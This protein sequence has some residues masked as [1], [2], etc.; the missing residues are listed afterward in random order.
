LRD[1]A[2][3]RFLAFLDQSYASVEYRNMWFDMY[4][5]GPSA[6]LLRRSTNPV[7]AAYS[8]LERVTGKPW[9]AAAF[10]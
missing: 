5:R 7:I 2:H 10:R 8:K 6:E 4:R 9:K 3:V 1:A